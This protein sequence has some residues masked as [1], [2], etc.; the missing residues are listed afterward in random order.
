MSIV[1]TESVD[2]YPHP[3]HI[4]MRGLGHEWM[5]FLTPKLSHSPL[6]CSQRVLDAI[7]KSGLT[8][9]KAVTVKLHP[10]SSKKLN[11]PWEYYWLIPTAPTY[12]FEYRFYRGSAHHNSYNFMFQTDVYSDSRIE[13]ADLQ[14]GEYI[15]FRA[16]PKIETW[17]RSDF[18]MCRGDTPTGVFGMMF[19]GRKV[20]DL[21]AKEKWTNVSF[22][23]IDTFIPFTIDHLGKSWP[24][25]SW[26]SPNEPD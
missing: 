26:Y 2:D 4:R 14:P 11:Q 10:P 6:L 9:Y 15:Y 7:R 5:D 3:I 21:A 17:D 25:E 18:N 8:G 20:V 24:P 23:P 19:C 12:E 16:I 22:C 1:G 13:N